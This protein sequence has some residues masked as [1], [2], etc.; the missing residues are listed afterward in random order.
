M[1]KICMNKIRMDLITDNIYNRHIKRLSMKDIKNKKFKL[2][3]SSGI[4]YN[5]DI[6][7]YGFDRS[8]TRYTNILDFKDMDDTYQIHM[9]DFSL[10]FECKTFTVHD[11]NIIFNILDNDPNVSV[12]DIHVGGIHG[13]RIFGKGAVKYLPDTFPI[14][15]I[16]ILTIHFESPAWDND[17]IGAGG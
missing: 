10:K 6:L 16:R 11:L 14:Q 9:L 4:I 12:I 1:G 17:L 13:S 8:G 3:I 5:S 2:Y 15:D 7:I